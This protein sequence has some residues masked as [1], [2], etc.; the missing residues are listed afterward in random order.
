MKKTV[1]NK[2]NTKVNYLENKIPDASTLIQTNQYDTNKKSL[3]EKN[4]EV[5]NRILDASG[6]VKKNIYDAEISENEKKYFISSDYNQ[7][8]V[9]ILDA[10]IEKE[11]ISQQI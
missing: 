6:F 2:V 4:G 9:D 3:E 10:E 11:K 5:E 7:F 1:H 8:T